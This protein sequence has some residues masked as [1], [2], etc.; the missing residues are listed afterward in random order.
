M[1]PPKMGIGHLPRYGGGWMHQFG[2][3]YA[4][5]QELLS[6]E[7][8]TWFRA[9]ELWHTARHEGLALNSAH[10][11]KILQAC[12]PAAQWHAALQV[13]SQMRRD[14]IRPDIVGVGSA[15]AACA[16]AQR[17]EEA[18]NTFRYFQGEAKM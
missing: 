9:I 17:W 5:Q 11:G 15:L 4:L 18:L 14:A 6:R 3:V 12:V 10:Y 8:R 13:L 1:R 2:H 7:P 16:R